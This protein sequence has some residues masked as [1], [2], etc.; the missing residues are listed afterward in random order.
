[1]LFGSHGENSKVGWVLA[2]VKI[3]IQGDPI[4]KYRPRFTTCGRFVKVYDSQDKI[5][6][7]TKLEIIEQLKFKKPDL[8]DSP[9]NVRC[10][11]H[12]PRPKSHYGSGKNK[13]SLKKLAIY[14]KHIKK[15]DV[16][17]LVKFIFDCMTGIVWKDDSQVVWCDAVKKYCDVSPKTE[18][19][20][21][22]P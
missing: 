1:M 12:M 5:K 2:M 15:P 3:E 7:K 9:V 19:T 11:F 20:V 16:D 10:V 6:N 8:F 21:W 14:E 17:N 22:E 4:P 13:E 18:I